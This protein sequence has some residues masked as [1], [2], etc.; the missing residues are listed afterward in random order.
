MKI[1]F[2]LPGY[3]YRPIGGYNV[4]FDYA[5]YLTANRAADVHVLYYPYQLGTPGRSLMSRFHSQFKQV[6][7]RS[8]VKMSRRRELDWRALMPEVRTHS[9]K[10]EI[11][12]LSLGAGDAVVATSPQT[13][14][15]AAN[16][17]HK[18]S[19]RGF[20]FLQHVE[21]W[22]VELEFLHST[23]RLPLELVAVA[24][25]IRDYCASVSGRECHVVLNAVDAQKYAPGPPLSDRVCVG[26]LLTPSNAR[27]RAGLAIAVLNDLSGMG[28]PCQ[29]FGTCDRPRDLSPSVAHL[30]NPT[31]PEL[32]HFYRTTRV[33][34]CTSSTE[35]F[36]L[37]PAEAAL[38][39]CAVVSTRNGGVEA[40][41]D[42]FVTF[43]G[44]TQEDIRNAVL[45]V[46]SRCESAQTQVER[47]IEQLAGYS[48]DDAA[49]AFADI[50]APDL[51]P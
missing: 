29:S 10:R 38:C 34:F 31:H 46:Y 35:G 41:G 16:L 32:L 15:L 50:V 28:I 12:R 33:F 37:A 13:A 48:P 24:P 17:V 8:L 2:I 47:G 19:A 4:V 5:E 11:E 36:G 30:S 45:E 42:D 27:K 51:Q 23:Y 1:V 25:W 26:T 40:Y 18:T 43:C 39:G 49:G 9:W 21:D 14:H 3:A 6:V 7:V 22:D 44:D 20:Y